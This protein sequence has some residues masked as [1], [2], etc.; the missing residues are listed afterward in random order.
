MLNGEVAGY[1]FQK[2]KLE[3][4]IKGFLKRKIGI[5]I[6]TSTLNLDIFFLS[7]YLTCLMT[8]SN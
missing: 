6:P 7:F 3:A 4:I 1:N 5:T 8:R 2:K